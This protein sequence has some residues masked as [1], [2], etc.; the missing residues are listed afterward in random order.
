MK[1]VN[2]E[3]SNTR[4]EFTDEMLCDI[5]QK[6]MGCTVAIC[7]Q[8]G[9]LFDGRKPDYEKTAV[10]L[11]LSSGDTGLGV[12]PEHEWRWYLS[13][14]YKIKVTSDFDDSRLFEEGL[15]YAL[16]YYGANNE[17]WVRDYYTTEYLEERREDLTNFYVRMNGYVSTGQFSC[18]F[19]QTSITEIRSHL[20]QGG[21]V[22]TTTNAGQHT[23]LFWGYQEAG[24]GSVQESL[25]N[26]FDPQHHDSADTGIGCIPDSEMSWY[27]T[28]GPSTILLSR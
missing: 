20:L 2:L 23:V 5:R 4:P 17:Q 6:P 13:H 14:G 26:V 28:A 12:D 9:W 21:L 18:E 3:F 1:N 27:V 15:D 24:Q 16:L 22:R 8:V 25:Y 19:G 7:D 10:E 11:G